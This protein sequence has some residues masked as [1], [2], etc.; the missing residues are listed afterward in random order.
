[1]KAA[2]VIKRFRPDI[3]VGTGGYVCGPVVLMAAF[4]GYP[5]FIQEQNALPGWT[6]RLLGSVVKGVSLGYEE[7]RQYFPERK[8]RVTGNPIRPEILTARR[9]EG[10]HLFGL[11][12]NKLTVL[13][14]GASQGAKAINRALIEGWVKLRGRGDLQILFVTGKRGFDDAKQQLATYGLTEVGDGHLRT[15]DLHIFPYLY[16]MPAAL[17]ASDL[18]VSRAGAMS[19]AEMCARGVPMV[20]VPLPHAAE[21]HQEKNARALAAR[22]AAEVILERDLTPETLV[23]MIE[24]L[25]DDRRRLKT[26]S[27]AAL[28]VGRPDAVWDIAGLIQ[29]LARFNPD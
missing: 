15:G 27:D 3:V 2:A 6:N 11:D 23:S 4:M 5:T 29:S 10:S 16:D 24:S 28:A 25:A 17:A 9:E 21:N 12:P 20:L 22:G 13:V 8:I 7:A 14:F 1:L 18:A 19:L 26:M